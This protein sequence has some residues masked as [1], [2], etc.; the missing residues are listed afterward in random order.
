MSVAIAIDASVRRRVP[1]AIVRA[2]SR[3]LARAAQRLSADPRALSVRIVDDAEMA[4]LHREHM[5]LAGP[6]DV[7]S[8]PVPDDLD[9]LGDVVIDWDAALRQA[10]GRSVLD[11]LTDLGVHGLAHLLGH[12][13]ETGRAG[14]RAML[15]VEQRACR[16]AGL[17]PP[18][19]PYGGAA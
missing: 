18:R 3:R 7:L 16:A 14:A 19:R 1:R 9:L 15:R 10:A 17:P 2:L 12:D 8:F 11:E 4:K 5:G 13:H 6:T